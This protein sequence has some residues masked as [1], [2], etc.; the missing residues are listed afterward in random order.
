MSKR[1]LL[2][3]DDSITIQKVVNLTFAD[4]GIEV[5]S[6]SDGN[7]AMDKLRED[8]PDLVLVDIN[9]PGL[10][11]Y[12]ICEK[13]KQSENG[14]KTPVILLVGSF[15]PFDENEARRVGADAYLTKPFQSISQ[16]VEKVN[17]LLDLNGNDDDDFEDTFEMPFSSPE[18]LTD[19]IE[20]LENASYGIGSFSESNGFDDEIIQ[21]NQIG[22]LPIDDAFKFETDSAIPHIFVDEEVTD[23]Q[24]AEYNSFK[25]Q[26]TA[27]YEIVGQQKTVFDS[28]GTF[29]E[30][31]ELDYP[32]NHSESEFEKV[33]NSQESAEESSQLNPA[34][35]IFEFSEDVAE[36]TSVGNLN[37]EVSMFDA[38]SDLDLDEMDLL[39]LPPLLDETTEEPTESTE[40]F[41]EPENYPVDSQDSQDSQNDEN[42]PMELNSAKLS[43]AKSDDINQ[44]MKDMVSPELVEMIT[45]KVVE[46][47]SEIAVREIAWEVVPQMADLIIKKLAEEK[48]KD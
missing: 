48:M 41:E 7:S 46:R 22:S 32:E 2:L 21:T 24:S 44:Q 38:F 11:G 36:K 14:K 16:L 28:D 33:Q 37:S 40:E 27:E 25:Q 18:N 9:M 12:E 8:L 1:K 35:N 34:E 30:K 19:D 45:K 20:E 29:G 17:D 4:E 3:A 10:N 26:E 43:A 15:E 5:I 47:L 42:P 13:I 31:T 6:V 39:E 23:E